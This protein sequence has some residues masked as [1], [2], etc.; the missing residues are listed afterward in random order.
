[1]TDENKVPITKENCKEGHDPKNPPTVAD[2]KR[3]VW[4]NP[5]TYK[6]TKG[7]E[8][9]VKGHWEIINKPKPKPPVAVAPAPAEA[10][11]EPAPAPEDKTPKK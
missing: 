3:P 2:G 1:M 11:T 10:K 9:L 4:H 7:T 6:N 8:I 5:Y